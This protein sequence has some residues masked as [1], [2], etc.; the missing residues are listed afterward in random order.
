MKNN[1]L[2]GFHATLLLLVTSLMCFGAVLNVRADN[3]SALT[4]LANFGTTNQPPEN[5]VASLIQGPDGLLYGTTAN[6][7]LNNEGTVFKIR[8]NGMGL[9][10]LRYFTN[11]PVAYSPYTNTVQASKQFF[12]LIAN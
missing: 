10:V 4:V 7:G 12:R 11:S 1:P 6:G 8:T 9:A 5:P 3:I 2:A